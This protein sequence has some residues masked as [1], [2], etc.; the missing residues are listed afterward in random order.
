MDRMH[1][2]WVEF[3]R[4]CQ[5]IRQLFPNYIG[6]IIGHGQARNYSLV[7][8][9]SETHEIAVLDHGPPDGDAVHRHQLGTVA[10]VPG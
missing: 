5:T 8:M 10:T 2:S 6:K 7:S 1:L 4:N 9:A 3:L